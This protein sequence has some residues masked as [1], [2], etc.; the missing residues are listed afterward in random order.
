[1][2]IFL[3]PGVIYLLTRS[4]DDKKVSKAVSFDSEFS[5]FMTRLSKRWKY[6]DFEQLWGSSDFQC[7]DIPSEVQFK[8]PD[9]LRCN[10][11][12]LKCIF[13]NQIKSINPFISTQHLKFYPDLGSFKIIPGGDLTINFKEGT[14][15]TKFS[16]RLEHN[17]HDT[18]LPNGKYSAG[19]DPQSAMVWDNIN[20]DIFIDKNYVTYRDLKYF[21]NRDVPQGKKLW[22][23]ATNLS[24]REMKNYCAQLGKK[25]LQSHIFDAA[26]FYPSKMEK[27]YLFK[28][29]YPWSKDK[30]KIAKEEITEKFC[31]KIYTKDCTDKYRGLSLETVQTPG[32]V[33]GY[34]MLGGYAEVFE[35]KF[36]PAANLKI[37]HH[38]L[39]K[40]NPWHRLGLRGSWSGKDF[41]EKDIS[42][43]ESTSQK[44]LPGN[45]GKGVAFRCMRL[46]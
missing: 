17:C 31:S 3:L 2:I 7:T 34:Y 43:F 4:P 39:S 25:L 27:G 18:Y 19:L 22:E 13:K 35:N 20:R 40:T 10:G 15:Q 14:T 42:Y 44:E 6:G 26:S 45:I 23:P 11:T 30:Y 46:K 38:L 37:S 12:Y 8:N 16:V 1:M 33:G 5:E 21:Q 28:S 41:N 36:L 9:F 32:W 29:F 24:L